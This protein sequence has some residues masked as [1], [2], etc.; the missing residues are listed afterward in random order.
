MGPH[1]IE[2]WTIITFSTKRGVDRRVDKLKEGLAKL[3]L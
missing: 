2:G 3:G 1:M